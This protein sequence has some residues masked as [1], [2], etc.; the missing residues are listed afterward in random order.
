MALCVHAAVTFVSLRVKGFL[1]RNYHHRENIYAKVA[2]PSLVSLKRDGCVKRS[3][4]GP[5]LANERDEPLKIL[6]RED[7]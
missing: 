2:N 1:T 6:T 5:T 7:R 3:R 4:Q